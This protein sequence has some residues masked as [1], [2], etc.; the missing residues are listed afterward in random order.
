MVVVVTVEVI[1]DPEPEVEPELDLPLV[2]ESDAE[3]ELDSPLVELDAES[4]SSTPEIAP[5][6][7]PA[8][9]PA[10]GV[11]SDS[12]SALLE[13]LEPFGIIGIAPA[14]PAVGTEIMAAA[15]T[16]S[17]YLEI[18]CLRIGNKTYL[19]FNSHPYLR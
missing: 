6:P 7:D 15:A 8:S 10:S 18:V 19:Y 11:G 12:A 4:E 1:F 2:F 16:P 14:T 3:S 9:D 17:A 5:E 13:L